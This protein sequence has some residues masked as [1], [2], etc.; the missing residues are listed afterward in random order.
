MITAQRE[1]LVGIAAFVTRRTRLWWVTVLLCLS[2]AL[3][4]CY[5]STRPVIKIGLVAPFEEL[6]RED[7]YAAL[8][9]V[10][11]AIAERNA[12]GG[13]GGHAIALVALNDNGRPEEAAMQASKLGLDRDVVGVIGPLQEA[14]AVGAAAE[15]AAQDLPWVAPVP[16]EGNVTGGWGLSASPFAVGG[17]AVAELVRLGAADRA[18]VFSDQPGALAGAQT[19]ADRLGVSLQVL[20]LA[21]GPADV[22][23]GSGV[24][25]LGDAERGA[26]LLCALPG[27]ATALVGGPEVGSPVFARRAAP[28]A[29]DAWLSSGPPAAAVS[30]QFSAA[31]RHLA[32]TAPSPQA[33][34]A[35]DAT[36]LLLDAAALA[37][38]EH[39]SLARPL[40]RQAL[41]TVAVRGWNGLAGRFVWDDHACEPQTGCGQWAE[42]P[43]YVQDNAQ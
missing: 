3:A 8:Y 32:A 24:A 25:W 5:G 15:L 40:V 19:A 12:Q 43:L 27:G 41:H 35:Y 4:G 36:N 33:V 26:A 10:K 16:L 23:G 39:G 38:E 11:L 17:A 22:P 21:A 31:Y 9:A 34:L 18:V 14:T 13:I 7:G 37:Y 1:P 2:V 6:Y 30:P 42:A 29:A 20:P 28:C